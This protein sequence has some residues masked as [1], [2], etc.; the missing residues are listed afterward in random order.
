MLNLIEK[1][2]QEVAIE[3]KK[4]VFNEIHG[5]HFTRLCVAKLNYAKISD[6]YTDS[7]G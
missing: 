3:Q 6:L 5:L 1:L 7:L 4:N 2:T